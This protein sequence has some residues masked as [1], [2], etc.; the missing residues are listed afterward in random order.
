[1]HTT[2]SQL[3]ITNDTNI[4]KSLN[5]NCSEV[6]IESEKWLEFCNHLLT[7]RQLFEIL[8]NHPGL[9]NTTEP[10]VHIPPQRQWYVSM[11]FAIGYTVLCI[12][13]VVGNVLLLV[14]LVR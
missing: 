1:M 14:T 11:L 3:D 12:W 9:L 13:G 6:N 10:D 2:A 7:D 4:T 5:W 8:Q